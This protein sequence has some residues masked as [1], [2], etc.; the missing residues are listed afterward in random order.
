VSLISSVF[1]RASWRG[2]S[3][4]RLW[5]AA[6]AAIAGTVAIGIPGGKR[7]VA[8][9]GAPPTCSDVVLVGQ[10]GWGSLPL[11][12]SL[13]NGVWSVENH[14]VWSTILDS[15]PGPSGFQ[16]VASSAAATLAADFDGDGFSDLLTVANNKDEAWVAT[17]RTDGLFHYT[18]IPSNFPHLY[19]FGKT[20]GAQAVVGRFL[21]N[22]AARQQVALVGVPGWTAVPV[23]QRR[24]EDAG[25]FSY[26]LLNS[27]SSASAAMTDFMQWSNK[28]YAGARAIAMDVNGDGL[29]D[30]VLVGGAGW[31]SIPVAIS[32]GDGTFTPYN[33]FGLYGNEAYIGTG[34]STA[35]FATWA[36]RKDVTI[37]P[38]HFFG[39]NGGLALVGGMDWGSVPVAYS[40]FGADIGGTL[41]GGWWVWNN[42]FADF[43]TWAKTAAF[44]V[45]GDFDGDGQT[46]I[47]LLGTPGTNIPVAFST[48]PYSGGFRVTNTLTPA[49]SFPYGFYTEADFSA[50]ART[51][52]VTALTGDFNGDK[53]TDIILVPGPGVNWS[54][55]PIAFSRGDGSFD[56]YNLETPGSDLGWPLSYFTGWSETSSAKPIVGE[57]LRSDT[58]LG[59]TEPN[60]GPPKVTIQ[61]PTNSPG[62]AWYCPAPCVITWQAVTSNFEDNNLKYEWGGL[63][64]YNPP[65]CAQGTMST[66]T[67]TVTTNGWVQASI[68]VTDAHGNYG[69]AVGAQLVIAI[70]TVTPTPITPAPPVRPTVTPA[71]SG[72]QSCNNPTGYCPWRVVNGTNYGPQFCSSSPSQVPGAPANTCLACGRVGESCCFHFATGALPDCVVGGTDGCRSDGVCIGN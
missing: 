56:I 37:L 14:S 6:L 31:G 72:G 71:N 32:K 53:K 18:K 9:A 63:P 10:N 3:R 25:F 8:S 17:S 13:C 54:T 59:R 51:P 28:T 55:M 62:T 58:T 48:T 46:D 65:N 45:T 1:R 70:P 41:D 44:K 49:P 69:T 11:A 64:V 19:T 26:T 42:G 67:C 5:V 34:W 43:S 52:G 36:A 66:T 30:I 7:N 2:F 12:K 57:F 47:A 29:D 50:W 20:A 27:P 4:T 16:A 15:A 38:G 39:Q 22:S 23:F 21:S 68:R 61:G 40:M 33:V 35:N 60:L 24:P